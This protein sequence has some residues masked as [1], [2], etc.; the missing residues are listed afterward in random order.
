MYETSAQS[1]QKSEQNR[2]WLNFKLETDV[3]LIS[4]LVTSSAI[5][6]FMTE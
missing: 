2:K 1:D 5:L 6:L 3:I 4:Q